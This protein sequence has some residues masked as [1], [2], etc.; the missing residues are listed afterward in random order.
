MTEL[1]GL[2][3]ADSILPAKGFLTTC[4]GNWKQWTLVWWW[5]LQP[6]NP[7]TL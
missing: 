6:W 7:R 5:A 3:P 2:Y 4:W 1:T